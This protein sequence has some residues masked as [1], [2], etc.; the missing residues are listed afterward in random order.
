MV[1]NVFPDNLAWLWDVIAMVIGMMQGVCCKIPPPYGPPKCA[2]IDAT[3][4]SWK[5]STWKAIHILCCF[6]NCGWCTGQQECGGILADLA[7]LGKIPAV[8]PTEGFPGY[9]EGAR[10]ESEEAGL[11]FWNFTTFVIEPK[12]L[13]CTL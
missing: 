2:A 13:I 12:S 10:G 5:L 8:V 9:G 7:I 4:K 1:L 11:I 3:F 6:V